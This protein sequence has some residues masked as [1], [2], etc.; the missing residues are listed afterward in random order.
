MKYPLLYFYTEES[1]KHATLIGEGI[2]RWKMYEFNQNNNA[3]VLKSLIK[4]IIQYL[5][6]TEIKSRLNVDISN[7]NFIDEPLYIY[8]EYYNELMEIST[9]VEITISYS[10]YN[11]DKFSK[12]ML[13]N[14]QYYELNIDGLELGDYKYEVSVIG[15]DANINKKGKFSIINSKE[16]SIILLQIIKD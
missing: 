15:T 6:K 16:K 2:W 12:K 10:N 13:S 8:A 5:K 9:N 1:T 4:K 11:G 3:D 7:E 14:N